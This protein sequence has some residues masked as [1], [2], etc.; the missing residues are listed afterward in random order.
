M[1][2]TAVPCALFKG[3]FAGQDVDAFS[4]ERCP[5]GEHAGR[6]QPLRRVVSPEP[7]L[8]RQI[9]ELTGQVAQ[10]Y[11]GTRADVLRLAVPPRH[12]TTEKESSVPAPGSTT[13][14]GLTT[15]I[16]RSTG[17]RS[18]KRRVGKECVSTC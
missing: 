17:P 9:A 8:A 1:S 13:G 11:A 10:R 12:A 16:S 14:S 3:R 18:E 15:G 4:L 2:N 7:V 6:L 5:V